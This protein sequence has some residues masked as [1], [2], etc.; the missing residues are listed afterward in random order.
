MVARRSLCATPWVVLLQPLLLGTGLAGA[1][2]PMAPAQSLPKAACPLVVPP[3]QAFFQPRRIQ[4]D[5]V[6]AKNARGCLSPA[7]AVY[8]TDGCPLRMCSPDAGVIP[9]P[10]P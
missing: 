10:Q 2:A 1:I 7:D 6:A 8:G 9:L 3:N 5:Q 4:P